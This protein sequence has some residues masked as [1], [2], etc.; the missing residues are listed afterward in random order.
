MLHKKIWTVADINLWHK[1]V[2][3]S[4]PAQI[5]LML[6]DKPGL[7]TAHIGNHGTVGRSFRFSLAT[8][9]PSTL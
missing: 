2:S 8:P 6:K 1:K 5:S 7:N 9:Q 4:A 3:P